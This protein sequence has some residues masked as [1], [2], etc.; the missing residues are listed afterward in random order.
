MTNAPIGVGASE[1]ID[2]DIQNALKNNIRYVV[3]SIIG[4]TET[5]FKDLDGMFFSW[6]S[7]KGSY[8]GDIFEPARLNNTFNI[9]GE[10]VVYVACVVDLQDM[11]LRWLDISQNTDC[12]VRNT[13][14]TSHG[15]IAI[16]KGIVQKEFVDMYQ[17]AMLNSIARGCI[18]DNRED[19]DIIISNDT[20]K[21]IINVRKERI[22]NK[23]D[24]YGTEYETK[25]A[26][27][28]D[29][30]VM[31]EGPGDRKSVG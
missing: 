14:T 5:K 19:A 29:V 25:R 20:T 4:Y 8:I 7:G 21:P 10:S 17:L 27:E 3:T 2:V 26:W 24:E 1:F 18:V 9:N 15:M 31:V 13:S 16:T 22:V 30:Q 6:Q 12:T 28:K 23:V 11:D